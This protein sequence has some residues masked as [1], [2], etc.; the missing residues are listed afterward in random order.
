V[1]YRGPA[2]TAGK[3]AAHQRAVHAW[4]GELPDPGTFT[5]EILPGLRRIAVSKLAAATGPSEH[6]C[7]LI[8]L[9]KKVPHPRHW[10]AFRRVGSA[11]EA[12]TSADLAGGPLA[13][14]G[15]AC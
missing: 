10:E 5:Q 8:R 6:Y 7:S 4:T 15:R 12:A 2:T 13:N 9:G 1:S 3:N 11:T 14:R